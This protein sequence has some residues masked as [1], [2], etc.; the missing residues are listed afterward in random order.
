MSR[1]W[2]DW[3][4][5][6]CALCLL[7]GPLGGCGGGSDGPVK[8]LR[9]LL[10]VAPAPTDGGYTF[11]PTALEPG[12]EAAL[13]LSILNSGQAVLNVT[14]L[15][16]AYSAP[17]DGADEGGP[18]LSC[19]YGA[20]TP[21]GAPDEL[22]ARVAVLNV[23]SDDPAALPLRV[24]FRRPADDAPREARLVIRSDSGGGAVTLTFATEKGVPRIRV[25][26]ARVQ[27]K[28][29]G[30]GETGAAEVAVWNAGTVDLVVDRLSLSGDS[31]FPVTLGA[32][33]WVADTA[34]VAG[35]DLGTPLVLGPERSARIT[36]GY[37]ADD[38]EGA[39]GT[40]SLH[41]ND[42]RAEWTAVLIEAL[43]TG[44]VLDPEPDSLE[45]G[46]RIVDRAGVLPLALVSRGTEPVTVSA[47][48]FDPAVSSPD[49]DVTTDEGAPVGELL[50]LTIAPG[51]QRTIRV[52]YTPDVENDV[53][54][55]T[56]TPVTDTGAL[57]L[58]SDGFEDRIA[59]P[60]SGWGVATDC[61]LAVIRCEE[62]EEVEPQTLLHLDGSGSV[63]R[64]GVVTDW[65]WE[66]EQPAGSHEV[67]LPSGN[68]PLT[69]FQPNIAGVYT[70]RLRVRDESGLWS[71]QPA[72]LE[73][74]VVPK[75]AIHVEL[76]WDTPGDPSSEDTG[77]WAGADVDLHFLHEDAPSDPLAPDLD[78]DGAPDPWFD[79]VFDCF[80]FNARPDWGAFGY[81]PDDPRLDRDD[82]DGWGPE[83]INLDEPEPGHRYTVAVHYWNDHLYGASY[84]TLRFYVFGTQ[85]HEIQAVRIVNYDLWCVAHIDWPSGA[86]TPCVGPDGGPVLVPNY[87]PRDFF[88]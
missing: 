80:W 7:G 12:G 39:S 40:L 67:F 69:T 73:V 59:V 28:G 63:A 21:C 15:E 32:E 14:A 43:A 3:C 33:T 51:D 10:E 77:A 49:F 20:G 64:V 58:E 55:L 13:D 1:R 52:R 5:F 85:V 36:I 86:I 48:A 31:A 26:P 16:W 24:R 57:V 35:V 47:I 9:P 19:T 4:V 76:I 75:D 88:P 70:F 11:A 68:L 81:R 84:A 72:V 44:P 22:P 66:V 17:A 46:P 2:M 45:F 8:V 53:D 29:L 23:P 60:T 37:T 79:R 50:P 34:T 30:R 71:C 41:A 62:G 82:T 18:A 25:S 65:E 54:E 78:E 87:R 6:M 27:F 83:N 74:V 42:P 38:R 61:P 56:G